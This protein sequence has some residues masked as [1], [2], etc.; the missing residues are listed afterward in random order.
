MEDIKRVKA[1]DI[2]RCPDTEVKACGFE[3]D[4]ACD[5]QRD[6]ETQGIDSKCG[7]A[8][9]W[10]RNQRKLWNLEWT[11]SSYPVAQ[12]YAQPQREDWPVYDASCDSYVEWSPETAHL[13]SMLE[14]DETSC[15]ELRCI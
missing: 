2:T 13:E 4:Y 5:R 12:S 7:Y 3:C 9:V 6:L 1:K 10:R 8:S 11:P 14:L 15:I